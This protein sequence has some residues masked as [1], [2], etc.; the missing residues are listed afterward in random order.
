LLRCL[1]R[2]TR[3]FVDFQSILTYLA[4]EVLRVEICNGTDESL[5]LTS[6]VI[7]QWVPSPQVFGFVELGLHRRTIAAQ[8]LLVD[9]PFSLEVLAILNRDLGLHQQLEGLEGILTVCH[10]GWG[11]GIALRVTKRW[12]DGDNL[13][14][15]GSRCAGRYAVGDRRRSA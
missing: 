1:P 4:F 6:H 11:L 2:N 12:R 7:S 3:R 13:R 15:T 8:Q 10:G 9:H 14:W 5:Q